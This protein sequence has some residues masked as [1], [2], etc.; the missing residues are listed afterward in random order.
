MDKGLKFSDLDNLIQFWTSDL[1]EMAKTFI[2]QA[3]EIN[4]YIF[5][6]GD[7]RNKVLDNFFNFILISFMIN[8]R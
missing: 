5:K 7:N 8:L 2:N 1:N 6:T 4:K 3:Q